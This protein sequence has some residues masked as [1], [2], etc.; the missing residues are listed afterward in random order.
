MSPDEPPLEPTADRRLGPYTVL[1][2]AAFVAALVTGE[3]AFAALAAP[4]AVAV[5]RALADRRPI[6]VEVVSIDA[7]GRVVEGDHWTI[8]VALGWAGRA[9]HDIVHVGAGGWSIVVEPDWTVEADGHHVVEI[10][11][12]A[13]R[14]G[15][16]P[17]GSLI[18]RSRRPG[19]MLR[20]DRTVPLPGEIRV[21]PR[22]S[23]LDDLLHPERPRAAAGGHATSATGSG[24]DVADLR[25]YAPGDRLRDLSWTATARAGEPW[26]VVRHPERSGTVV[27]LLDGFADAGAPP[28]ALDR[29]ARVVWSIARHHLTSGD[30]VG[31][32]ASGPTPSW[33]WPVSGRRARWQVLDALL[34]VGAAGPPP[35]GSRPAARRD[36]VLPADAV[37]VGVSPLHSDAFVAA[38]AHHRRLGRDPSVVVVETADL[39]TP[40]TDEIERAAR[41][42]W[43]IDVDVRRAELARAGVASVVV[44][45]DAAPAARSL[46]NRRHRAGRAA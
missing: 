11:A 42:L 13:D 23:R 25:P 37:V 16:H 2:V 41:R 40:P 21:L 38:V 7:P 19:G 26:V 32:L 39:L 44:R 43:R 28:A 15:R 6:A 3:A 29:A 46:G 1:A 31:L 17:L 4:V 30:R 5:V 34:S 9:V 12:V 22:A 33:L 36:Q 35:L 24:T 20:W 27:L 18:I 10:A 45:D 8:R 14:W